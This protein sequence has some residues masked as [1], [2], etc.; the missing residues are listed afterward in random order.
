M[1][2]RF[3]GLCERVRD[4]RLQQQIARLTVARIPEAG[5]FPPS[6]HPEAFRRVLLPILEAVDAR[7]V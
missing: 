6:E 5:H 7:R 1:I 2:N 3:N 4:V